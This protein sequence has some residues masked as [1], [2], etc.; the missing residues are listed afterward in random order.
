MSKAKGLLWVAGVAVAAAIAVPGLPWLARHVPWFVERAVGGLIGAGPTDTPCTGH[1]DPRSAALFERLVQRVY[2][3][4]ADDAA[5]PIS[6]AVIPGKT[7]NAF[8]TLGG[9]IFVFDGLLQKA[10]SPE[11][12]AGVLAHE[13]EHVRNRHII[14]GMAVNLLTLG[15]V[16]GAAHGDPSAGSR[17]AYLLLTLRFS[18][19]QEEEADLRGLQRLKKA[20]VDAAGFQAFFD[21]AQ[22]MSEPPQML[23]N[24]PASDYRAQLAA[25][26]RGYPVRPVLDDGDWPVFQAICK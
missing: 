19:Q 21:R 11:E 14:Q 13:I 17:L 4:D 25:Q 7:V 20:Q 8:A 1:A 10:Q 26:F 24:H 18:R 2:P 6:I 23:S 12:L 9:H 22:K 15:A 5:L 3:L 16:T